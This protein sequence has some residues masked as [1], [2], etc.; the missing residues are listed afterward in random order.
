MVNL[1][2]YNLKNFPYDNRNPTP[3]EKYR[4]NDPLIGGAKVVKLASSYISLI[5]GLTINPDN[6]IVFEYIQ[7]MQ[8]MD[9]ATTPLPILKEQYANYFSTPSKAN[10]FA[11]FI[12]IL[13]QNNI[14]KHTLTLL[15]TCS[16]DCSDTSIVGVSAMTKEYIQRLLTEGRDGL[17]SERT[18]ESVMNGLR[19]DS[20]VRSLDNTI[21]IGLIKELQDVL[22]PIVLTPKYQNLKFDAIQLK[23]L[24]IFYSIS[25]IVYGWTPMQVESYINTWRAPKSYYVSDSVLAALS[26]INPVALEHAANTNK[27]ETSFRGYTYIN[28]AYGFTLTN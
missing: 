12:D 27:I 19:H 6:G 3:R 14:A 26:D 10:D 22:V 2:I 24:K 11:N 7:S 16:S 9:F 4:N 21:N 18:L 5:D 13:I 17:I 8:T 15:D 25:C 1:N 28:N 23:I 20:H